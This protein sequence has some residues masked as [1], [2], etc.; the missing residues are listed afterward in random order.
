MVPTY[1]FVYATIVTATHVSLCI[2]D[3]CH[4]KPRIYATVVTAALGFFCTCQKWMF[5]EIWVVWVVMQLTPS[6]VTNF[7]STLSHHKHINRGREVHER[8]LKSLHCYAG[9]V[10][11]LFAHTFS[12]EAFSLCCR[13]W[14]LTSL[15][16]RSS[17]TRLRFFEVPNL[18]RRYNCTSF[19]D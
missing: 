3:C 19:H 7:L 15:E 1:P 12:L 13:A 2:C 6:V 4:C 16:K 10:G 17:R 11:T 5:L 18:K 8:R 14:R 9:G